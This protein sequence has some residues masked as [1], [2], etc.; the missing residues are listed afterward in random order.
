MAGS[1]HCE[2]PVTE[3]RMTQQNDLTAEALRRGAVPGRGYALARTLSQVL[4]PVV[5]SIVSILFV[6]IVGIAEQPAG[7]F[8]ALACALFQVVPP[9]IFFTI[10]LRQGVY[11]DEDVS[12][13]TQRNE[14]YI[15]GMLNLAVGCLL[16]WLLRA[17]TPFLAMLISATLINLLAW[18]TNLS[19]KISV[20]AASMSST[21]TIATIYAPLIGLLLWICAAAL[22]WA[23]VRTR[24]HTPGQVIAGTALA[25]VCV[26]GSF[27][28]FGLI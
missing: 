15:F 18:L 11:T 13:R 6:G 2:P 9:T 25:A 26:L 10:R 20:H 22:G 16:L 21:A 24:N 3:T 19:W 27:W 1:A 4:H 8:W 14:L 17:P 7:L 23:R 5:L 12:D 28:V